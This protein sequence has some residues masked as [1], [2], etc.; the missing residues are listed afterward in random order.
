MSSCSVEIFCFRTIRKEGAAKWTRPAGDYK[1]EPFL[2][3]FPNRR[4]LLENWNCYWFHIQLSEIIFRIFHKLNNWSVNLPS[5]LL[6]YQSFFFFFSQVSSYLMLFTT[7]RIRWCF[8]F[9]TSSLSSIWVEFAIFRV[10]TRIECENRF[11]LISAADYALRVED[12]D[13][14]SVS[15][16]CTPSRQHFQRFVCHIF[17]MKLMGL[18]SVAA[19][20]QQSLYGVFLVL[21]I[22]FPRDHRDLVVI[23]FKKLMADWMLTKCNEMNKILN[24]PSSYAS[25]LVLGKFRSLVLVTNFPVEHSLV[26]MVRY[27]IFM[28]RS[29]KKLYSFSLELQLSWT[30]PEG[31]LAFYTRWLIACGYILRLNI[32]CLFS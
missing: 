18:N 12:G 4:R 7:I 32:M 17:K 6:E 26:W 23:L 25:I 21:L 10:Q 29:L 30:L 16:N 24:F 5:N 11:W 15:V 20:G 19:E 1:Y 14:I 13:F 3:N 8:F 22:I 28:L 9:L 2:E 27:E 31:S